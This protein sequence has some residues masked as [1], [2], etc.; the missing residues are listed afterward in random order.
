MRA[1]ANEETMTKK[2]WI[3]TGQVTISITTRVS[4]TSEAS[5]KRIAA[6]RSLSSVNIPSDADEDR[7]WVAGEELD[8][9]PVVIG[10]EED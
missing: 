3:V 4:A 10:A 6:S 9:D 5:A 1:P 8:G 2:V 7:E